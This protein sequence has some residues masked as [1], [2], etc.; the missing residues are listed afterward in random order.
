VLTLVYPGQYA[1]IDFRNWRQIFGERKNGFLLHDYKQY[2]EQVR[3]LANELNWTVQEVDL[4]VQEYDCRHD[5]AAQQIVG[6]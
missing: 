4:A 6:S 5:G 2:M 1:V 3:G